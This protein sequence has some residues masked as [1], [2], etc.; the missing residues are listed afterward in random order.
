MLFSKFKS[1]LSKVIDLPLPGIEAQKKMVPMFRVEELV[2]K[3]LDKKTAKKS[4]VL[5]LFYPNL[6]GV[7]TPSPPPCPRSPGPWQA[8]AHSTTMKGW[9]TSCKISFSFLM[10]STCF[11]LTTSDFFMIFSAKK[12]LAEWM[13]GPSGGGVFSS[14]TRRSGASQRRTRPKVPVPEWRVRARVRLGAQVQSTPHTQGSAAGAPSVSFSTISSSTFFFLA[15]YARTCVVTVVGSTSAMPS[16]RP[17]QRPRQS[18][19]EAQPTA[20]EFCQ[21]HLGAGTG[22]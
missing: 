13:I 7:P 11:S 1:L 19:V 8:A 20:T 21:Q 9:L 17:P 16:S 2:K 22:L 14:A 5:L 18:L 4:A 10:C 6:H 15:Q 3:P 12:Q